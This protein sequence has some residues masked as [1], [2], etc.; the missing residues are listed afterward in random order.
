MDKINWLFFDMG[1]TLIDETQ[2]Y[3]GWFRSASQLIGGAL[4]AEEIEKAYCAGMIKGNPTIAGQLNAYGFTGNSTN[5]LYPSE[6][7]IPY[8]EAEKVLD[9]LF[10]TYKLGIIANQNAGSE[11]RLKQYCLR[12]YF[13]VIVASAEAGVKKPDPRIFRLAL[14]QANCEPEQAAMI[15]DRLDNDIFPANA[16]GFTTVRILQGYGRLQVPKSAEYEPDFT[17]DTLM[18][19]LNIF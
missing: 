13:D 17:V 5:H 18:Q 11:L 9:Q 10:R 6:L 1:S 12:Q 8:P 15:G 14:E 19:L 4:S 16:L 3:M 2:S 7:D